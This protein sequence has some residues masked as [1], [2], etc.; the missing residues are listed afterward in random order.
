MNEKP[1]KAVHVAQNF[2]EASKSLSFQKKVVEE[3]ESGD[4]PL[5]EKEKRALKTHKD[6]EKKLHNIVLA[7]FHEATQDPLGKEFYFQKFET[8]WKVF[9]RIKNKQQRDI[10]LHENAFKENVE[11]FI[12]LAEANQ[13]NDLET[14]ETPQTIEHRGEE[15]NGITN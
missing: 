4:K 7:Y 3:M 13:K 10:I 9:A 5:S 11:Y 1:L 15:D 6:S 8:E 14:Q 2:S 12:K